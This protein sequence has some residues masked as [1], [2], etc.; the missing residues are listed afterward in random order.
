MSPLPAGSSSLKKYNTP[1]THKTFLNELK[2]LLPETCCP[3]IVTDA[4]FRGPWFRD[5]EALGWHWVG[6]I[7][8]SIK[9]FCPDSQRWRPTHSLY[10]EATPRMTYLGLRTLA[11]RRSYT[12]HL[13]LMRAYVRGPG[14]PRK[15]P[16]YGTNKQLYRILH[17]TP[18]LLASSLPHQRSS[19]AVIKRLY[20][21]RMQIEETFR[22]LKSHRWGFALRYAR[23]RR[24]ERME[25]LLLIAALATLLLWLLGIAA[26]ARDWLRR[27]QANTVRHRDVLSTVFLGR[28]VAHKPSIRFHTVEL[29]AAFRSLQNMLFVDAQLRE[30]RGDP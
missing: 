15:R 1:R 3:I 27:F 5:V 23:T 11:R 30:L 28:A 25:T 14:R 26:R 10:K 12:C 18:W 24:T 6:R 20:T 29:L 13:Y 16:N 19:N 17:R 4:G 22:D 7:R 9:Y 21:Q 2:V 8:N